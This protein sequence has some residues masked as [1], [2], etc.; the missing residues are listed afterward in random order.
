MPFLKCSVKLSSCESGRVLANEDGIRALVKLPS[1]YIE[2][3]WSPPALWSSRSCC[4]S[5]CEG[6]EVQGGVH[7]DGTWEPCSGSDTDPRLLGQQAVPLPAPALLRICLKE[8]RRKTQNCFLLSASCPE[9]LPAAAR[10]PGPLWVFVLRDSQTF[11]AAA[12]R[13]GRERVPCL[14]WL[15]TRMHL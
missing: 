10:L 6:E 12:A 14:L 4:L 9:L 7:G 11:H 15:R 2:L 5:G 1:W 3:S 8:Q 13:W